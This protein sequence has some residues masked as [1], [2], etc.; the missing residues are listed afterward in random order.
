MQVR[1][2]VRKPVASSYSDDTRTIVRRP[3]SEEQLAAEAR[4]VIAHPRKLQ[5]VEESAPSPKA[6][7]P[8]ELLLANGAGGRP[9]RFT[10]RPPADSAGAV[11]WT[12]AVGGDA[13]VANENSAPSHAALVRRIATGAL[14]LA[15]ALAGFAA[16]SAEESA[17][18][19]TRHAAPT[20]VVAKV[21]PH[22]PVALPPARVVQA[23]A[24]PAM[25]APV[26]MFAPA[27]TAPADPVATGA[28]VAPITTSTGAAA[29][30]AVA[31]APAPSAPAKPKRHARRTASVAAPAAATESGPSRREASP[32]GA[33]LRMLAAKLGR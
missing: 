16:W 24:A 5:S 17:M 15:G 2:I 22:A 27:A 32:E 21:A 3:P 10:P 31:T 13:E 25:P 9:A 4:T 30:P 14:W 18:F 29:S 12:A 23:S 28:P 19:A 26:M 33:D 7:R 11:V 8:R 20:A 6:L 1:R